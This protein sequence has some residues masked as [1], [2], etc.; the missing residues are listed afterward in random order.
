[1]WTSSRFLN[2]FV[3]AGSIVAAL[4]SMKDALFI[5]NFAFYWVPQVIL[6]AFLLLLVSRT[7]VLSGVVA[8]LALYLHLYGIWVFSRPNPES[9]AWLGYKLSL[10]S[11]WLGAMLGALYLKHEGY[12]RADISGAVAALFTF[13][14]LAVNKLFVRSKVMCCGLSGRSLAAGLGMLIAG[15]AQEPEDMKLGE[16][17]GPA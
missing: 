13:A 2:P 14:G 5:G 9:M 8:I 6:Y 4:L 10:P 7:A 15:G 3:V 1:M 11:A 17:L 16:L 12:R